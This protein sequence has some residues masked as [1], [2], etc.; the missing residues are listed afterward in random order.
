M[1]PNNGYVLTEYNE[2]PVSRTYQYRKVMKPMLERKRRARINRCLDELKELIVGAL[3]LQNQAHDNEN[4]SKLEKADILELTV[5]HLHAL[6][7]ANR[8]AAVPEASYAERFRA[9]FSHCAAEVS[10]F[11]ATAS[12]S[13][14]V[15]VDQREG[16]K[17]M[18]HLGGCIRRLELNTPPPPPRSPSTVAIA[19]SPAQ[20]RMFV[21]P[22]RPQQIARLPHQMQNQPIT[23][24]V[25]SQ[26]MW[27][28]W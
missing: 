7:R 11:L 4:I 17:L 24:S 8:L 9:G 16:V 14:G 15:R 10:Q 6:K 27:R 21:Q 20:E 5:S 1:A 25:A 23:Q 2:E 13:D 18:Q 12:T 3:Q 22:Q 28:P 26:D 19:P